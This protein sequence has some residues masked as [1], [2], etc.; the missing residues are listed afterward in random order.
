MTASKNSAPAQSK[1]LN[2]RRTPTKSYSNNKSS[3][4][5]SSRQALKLARQRRG[6]AALVLPNKAK[7]VVRR[8]IPSKRC[9]RQNSAVPARVGLPTS[10]YASSPHEVPSSLN[11]PTCVHKNTDISVS[12]I[13]TENRP[14]ALTKRICVKCGKLLETSAAEVSLAENSALPIEPKPD[15]QPDQNPPVGGAVLPI[16]TQAQ[17]QAEWASMPLYLLT[18]IWPNYPIL[19]PNSKHVNTL[20]S[21]IHTK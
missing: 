21:P 14:I 15:A 7:R 2:T 9:N 10:T 8:Y 20:R 13:Q 19:T 16:D 5:E 18:P 12:I 17:A 3:S 1:A 4:K 11:P 6:A